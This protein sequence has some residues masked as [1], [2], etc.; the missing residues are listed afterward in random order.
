MTS[1]QCEDTFS[2]LLCALGRNKSFWLNEAKEE[3]MCIVRV[4]SSQFWF[5]DVNLKIKSNSSHLIDDVVNGSYG[6]FKWRMLASTTILR[7]I[8]EKN[9]KTYYLL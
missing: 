3:N 5:R 9:P 7:P 1:L 4:G 6:A 2:P 8:R